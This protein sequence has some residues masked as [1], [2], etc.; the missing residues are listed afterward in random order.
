MPTTIVSIPGHLEARALN[1]GFKE[2]VDKLNETAMHGQEYLV[3]QKTD[4]LPIAVPVHGLVVDVE[5]D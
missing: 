2:F 4:G 3:A 5:A 1:E